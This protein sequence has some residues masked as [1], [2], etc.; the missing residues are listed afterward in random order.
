[1][2]TPGNIF[3]SRGSPIQT[4]SNEP[5]WISDAQLS[6]FIEDGSVDLFV[7]PVRDGRSAG[8]RTH[9][10]RVGPGQ[11]MTGLESDEAVS[12]VAF[13][14]VASPLSHVHR[15]PLN[16]L[17]GVAT[18]TS[19][20]ETAA[21][22]ETWIS[23]LSNSMTAGR[24][25]T[26]CDVI[27]VG[28]QLAAEPGAVL[29]PA[30]KV[31]WVD[32]RAGRSLVA[33][34]PEM[35]V[36]LDG[37]PIPLAPSA[38]LVVVTP[39]T[40]ACLSTEAVLRSG[41]V[42]PGLK[43]FG[44]LA[45][46]WAA[47]RIATDIQS[48]AARLEVK[49]RSQDRSLR[50]A[51]SYLSAV[52]APAR[53]GPT[54]AILE[55]DP[56]VVACQWV[57]QAMGIRIATPPTARPEV[58]RRNPLDYIAKTSHIRVRRVVLSGDWWRQDAGPLLAF[59]AENNQPV[60]LLP[61]SA[62]RYQVADP[63]T[64][65]RE[66]VTEEVARSLNAAA[67]CFCATFPDEPIKLWHVFQLGLRNVRS[68]TVTILAAALAGVLLGMIF[69]VIT[70]IVFDTVIPGA[71][72]SQL[73]YLAAA[74]VVASI[75]DI[76]LGITQS[77]ALMRVET[78]SDVTVQA[79]IW[80]RLLRLPAP[81]FR[82]FTSGDLAMRANGINAIRQMLSGVIITSLF[83]GAFSV[84]YFGLLCYYSPK[85]TVVACGLVAINLVM[86][87][88]TSVIMLRLQ[89]PMY[90][91]DGRLSGMV[92]QFITGIS[93]L[94]VAGAEAQAF[95]VWARMFSAQKRLDWRSGLYGNGFGI[96]NEL[97]PMITNMFL[98]TGAAYW[99]EPNMSTGKYLA[100]STAFM[101]FLN[102][103]MDASSAL[104]SI[105]HAIP[106][107]ER[108][109][110][111]LDAL[112]EVTETKADPG[113]LTGRVELNQVAF[114]YKPD[115]PLV[116]QEVSFQVKAGEFVAIVGP[117]GSGKSTLLRLLLGF[118]RPEKGAIFYDGQD[119]QGLDIQA[120]R[121]QFGVVLQ[122]G[123]LMPG[124][125]FQN[126]VGSGLRTL[127]E[128]W[129]AARLAGLEED[130]QAMPM[131]MHTVLGEGA[132]TLSG[133]QRQRLMIARAIVSK[134]RILL[135][136]EATSSLDNQTQAIVSHSLESLKATRIVIAHRL[137]TIEHADRIHVLVK[138][139]LA[140][141]GTFAELSNRPGPL[142]DMVLRQ[143]A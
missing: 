4:G 45:S 114:R 97:F 26:Q 119:L 130:I 123:K 34:L 100:F 106:L 85:L 13:L 141:S 81:F 37:T 36:G 109:R 9:V 25:P 92:L 44:Q 105:V 87:A 74:L 68:E 103:T 2:L 64:G 136:D 133:G 91:L 96:F 80:D 61:L 122:N 35:S 47:A 42:R 138:G 67:H 128:A 33:G 104:I 66:P 108:A 27:D 23:S 126:I 1:M 110:P 46:R 28:T 76:I 93:K 143:L 102:S 111:I 107:Y 14:A 5:F 75:T 20:R 29:R 115:T 50:S 71:A 131:G 30:D 99:A 60:A 6:W 41:R 83:S 56:L 72:R 43:R 59:R 7:V 58:R 16:R 55:E 62:T 22:L 39:A 10:L 51:V 21:L 101:I 18:A 113:V 117:S 140:Q 88:I 57:G 70:G 129:E 48:E 31:L 134:P 65:K 69:P 3:L 19:A 63:V 12:P 137:S 125:I 132:G 94:R 124:D 54:G 24:A 121:R 112:P 95:A 98:F 135:F 84:L 142:A 17:T 90:D 79:A 49:A 116:L 127:E 15:L 38:W 118:E 11:L 52:L 86:V 8:P 78:K 82:N 32:H 139:R 120:V 40:L 73:W 89:R 53:V 77:V